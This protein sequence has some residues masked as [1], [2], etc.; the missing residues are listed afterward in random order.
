MFMLTVQQQHTVCIRSNIFE[1]G[2]IF[3]VVDAN[4]FFNSIFLC[5]SEPFCM[6]TVCHHWYGEKGHTF[7][8]VTQARS[9]MKPFNLQ[10]AARGLEGGA[11]TGGAGACAEVSALYSQVQ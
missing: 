2:P 4:F 6:Q 3:L 11:S 1:V 9:T 5:Q 10:P 8:R 7:P